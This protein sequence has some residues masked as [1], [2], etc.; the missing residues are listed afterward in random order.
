MEIFFHVL[1]KKLSK[2]NK[3]TPV[4]DSCFN[5]VAVASLRPATLLKERLCRYAWTTLLYSARFFGLYGA[6][7]LIDTH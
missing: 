2:I 7:I 6:R 3:E 5:K 4:S 1:I